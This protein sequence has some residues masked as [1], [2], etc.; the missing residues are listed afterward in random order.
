MTS[1]ENTTPQKRGIINIIADILIM[2]GL[3]ALDRYTKY[4]AVLFLKDKKPL[5][6]IDGIFELSYL[7]N[8]GAAF[9]IMQNMKYFFLVVAV[10]MILFVFYALIRLPKGSRFVLLE[11]C[12]LL[13]GAG[14]V[15]N[16]IDRVSTEYVVDFFYFVL[17]NFPIFNV[18]DIYVTVACFVLI[19]GIL[20]VYKEEDL[21][22]LSLKRVKSDTV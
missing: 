2:A 11:I 16:M 14:A 22:F 12:L 5:V 4:L 8:R 7:E 13:I 18:A 21:K 1:N 15:G 17:I 6:L 10:V 9:G 3:I 19:I 20:F